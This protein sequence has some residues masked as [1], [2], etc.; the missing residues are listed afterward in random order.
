MKWMK[1]LVVRLAGEAHLESTVPL[2]VTKLIED[3][4]DLLNEKCATAL[5]RIGTSAVLEA[6][7]EAY[8]TAPHH[9]RLYATEPLEYIRSDLAIEKCLLLLRLEKDNGIRV[10]LAYALLSQF[11]LEGVEETRKLLMEQ[12]LDFEGRGLRNYLVETCTIMGERFPEYDEWRATEK[13]EKKEHWKR[14]K[15]LE[16]DP[17]GLIQ[18]ALEKLTGKTSAAAL[19]QEPPV[20]RLPHMIHPV[21]T[22][23]KQRV[24]RNEPCPCGS[25]KKFKKCCM[26]KSEGNPLFN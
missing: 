8:P 24:G 21:K 14:V 12:E 11:A 10:N 1:P 19:K 18:F 20:S 9:F 6:V 13:A 4:G 16:N 7:A 25:G 22:E 26:N 2:I 23:S 17:A 3:C 15:E 5:S